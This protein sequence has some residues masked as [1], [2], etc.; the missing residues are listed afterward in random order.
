MGSLPFGMTDNE[1]RVCW[2]LHKC[3]LEVHESMGQRKL[4]SLQAPSDLVSLPGWALLPGFTAHPAGLF[5]LDMN[6]LYFYFFFLRGVYT[7]KFPCS[8]FFKKKKQPSLVS[9]AL[10]KSPASASSSN[11]N[12][13]QKG[14]FCPRY[15]Y[16]NMGVDLATFCP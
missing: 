3:S 2:M 7:I 6:G 8:F 11:N 9:C 4:P 13:T 1:C 15:S 16:D 14:L 10:P 5:P 12:K